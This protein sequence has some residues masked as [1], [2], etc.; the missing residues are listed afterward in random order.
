MGAFYLPA[1]GLESASPADFA[2]QDRVD[3]SEI[4]LQRLLKDLILRH[5]VSLKICQQC[6]GIAVVSEDKDLNVTGP[7]CS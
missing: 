7:I 3:L 2:T 5:A 4:F 1:T 6:F